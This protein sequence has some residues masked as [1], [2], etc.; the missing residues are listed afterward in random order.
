MDNINRRVT[1]NFFWLLTSDILFKGALFLGTIYIARVLGTVEFGLFSFALAVTNSIWGVADLGVNQYGT[2]QVA[3]TPNKAEELLRVLNSLRFFTSILVFGTFFLILT[4]VH[5]PQHKKAVLLA[6]AVYLIAYGLSPEWLL[7]GAET[8]KYLAI[9]NLIMAFV[10]LPSIFLL[11]GDP[12]DT[13]WASFLWGF[14]F[15]FGSVGTIY[16]L[17]KKLNIRFF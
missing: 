10:F 11:V 6:S 3:R 8:M 4:L 16:L 1:S 5:V 2:R 9:G 17:W 13:V 12:R 14:S 15:F 7:R